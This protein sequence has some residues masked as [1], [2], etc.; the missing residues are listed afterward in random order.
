MLLPDDDEGK[1]FQVVY[2]TIANTP[3]WSHMDLVVQAIRVKDAF[4]LTVE[5]PR[6]PL[7]MLTLCDYGKIVQKL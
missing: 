2:S 5:V 7:I 1:D 6:Q 4:N 3:V